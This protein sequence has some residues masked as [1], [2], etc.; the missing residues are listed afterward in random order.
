MGEANMK[1]SE[2][3]A[4]PIQFINNR[5]QLISSLEEYL[6]H[7]HYLQDIF[8]LNVDSL[9]NVLKDQLMNRLLIPVYI[10]SLIKRD[11]FS[12]VKFL[13]YRNQNSSDLL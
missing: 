7:I 11:K 2:R 5:G 1:Y 10:F 6:D 9:N 12:R 3:P 13:N 8:L 4:K